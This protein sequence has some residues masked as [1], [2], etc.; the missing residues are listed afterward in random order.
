MAE[1]A[2]IA[3]ISFDKFINGS[4]AEKCS[5]AKQIYDSFSTVG[6]VYLKDHGIPQERVDGIFRLVSHFQALYIY[7]RLYLAGQILLRSPFGEEIH[8]A[9][10]R[11]RDKSRLYW[12]WRRSKRRDRPQRML[13]APPLQKSLLSHR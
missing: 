12:R 4:E 7:S 1:E 2:A 11:C 3:V 9:P 10:Q 13:R 6:W 5:V 8:L